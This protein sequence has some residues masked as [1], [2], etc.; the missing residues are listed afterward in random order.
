MII[1]LLV[2]LAGLV[3]SDLKSRYVYIW[4]LAV[5]LVVQLVYCFFTFGKEI[6]V[7]NAFVNSIFL[8]ILSL[9]VSIYILFR[10]RQKKGLIG[11]GD[12]LFILCLTPYFNLYRFLLFMIISMVVSL[13]GWG[14]FY[15]VGQRS[16]EIPLISTLGICYSIL[17][18][19]DNVIVG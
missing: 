11:W 2:L 12:I 10:F 15:L 16:K 13:G 7:Q 18:I 6:M 5:F 14:I 17:L 9:C 1:L 4:Q 3:I 8:L 19:Y